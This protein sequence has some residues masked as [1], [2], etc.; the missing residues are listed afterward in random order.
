ML[1]N[2]V[3]SYIGTITNI[4]ENKRTEEVLRESEEQ[5]RLALDLTHIGS[6]DW[7][8]DLNKVTW[9]D[10]HFRLLGLQPKVVA[11]SYQ[12]WRDR[13]H[14]EDIDR[15]E[16]IVTQALT[17]QTD[18]EK[19]TTKLNIASSTPME[20]AAGFWAKVGASTMRRESRYE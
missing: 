10:N 8:I 16:Q 4:T 5:R 14:R 9:N 6:W 1:P 17:S 2:R 7:Q 19:P 15:V 3:I 13:V 11:S 18:Y 20:R 12:A